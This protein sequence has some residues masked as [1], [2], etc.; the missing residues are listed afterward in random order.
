MII[1]PTNS[2]EASD[3]TVRWLDAASETYMIGKPTDFG[4]WDKS[5]GRWTVRMPETTVGVLMSITPN[6]RVK[7]QKYP[8]EDIDLMRD[9]IYRVIS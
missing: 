5:T 8:L 3:L 1:S 2:Y 4:T 7:L 9:L 6:S